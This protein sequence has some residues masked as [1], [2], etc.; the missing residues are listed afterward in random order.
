MINLEKAPESGT[1]YAVFTDKILYQKFC[2][3]EFLI[4]DWEEGKLLELHL[5]DD[6]KE[7]RLIRTRRYGMLECEIT[8]ACEHDDTYEEKV[9]VSG[10]NVDRQENLTKQAAVVNYITYDENDLLHIN[11]YRLKEVAK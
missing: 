4:E 3:D 8:D 1:M 7:Y 5:F 11:N 2:R 6:R 10:S 9:Y